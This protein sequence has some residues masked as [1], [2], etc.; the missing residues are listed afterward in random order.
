MDFKSKKGTETVEAAL[1]F[2]LII[3]AVM[4]LIYIFIY[5]YQGTAEQAT[6]HI[7]LRKEAGM[8]YGTVKYQME[9]E[10]GIPINRKGS[11]VFYIKN[12]AFVQQGILQ[13]QM[14]ELNGSYYIVRGKTIVRNADLVDLGG[15]N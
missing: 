12:I 2:P 13:Q 8:I 5:F 14:R 1:V 10:A 3:L 6:A 15:S 11:R 7:A 4:G 9:I